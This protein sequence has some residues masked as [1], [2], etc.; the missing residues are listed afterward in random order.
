M[1]S[2]EKKI[3]LVMLVLLPLDYYIPDLWNGVMGAKN[4]VSAKVYI[5]GLIALIFN[6][7]M[8][9]MFIFTAISVERDYNKKKRIK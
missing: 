8:L 2:L 5:M 9:F 1:S 3:F 4:S 6:T 7:F